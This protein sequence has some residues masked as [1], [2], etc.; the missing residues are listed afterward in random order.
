MKKVKLGNE[1]DLFWQ[2]EREGRVE[3]LRL[4]TNLR[5][6]LFHG[7]FGLNGKELD[8][9]LLGNGLIRAKIDKAAASRLGPYYIDLEYYNPD[10]DVECSVDTCAFTMVDQSYKATSVD[11]LFLTSDIAV[12]LSLEEGAEL[13]GDDRYAGKFSWVYNPTFDS[14]DLV[15]KK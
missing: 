7:A 1:F 8:F 9:T 15:Y 13:D 2:L 4:A 3:D 6:R 10:L 14:L 12:A 11:E 5:L